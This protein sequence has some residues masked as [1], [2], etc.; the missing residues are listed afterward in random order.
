MIIADA[1]CVVNG[2]KVNE[3]IDAINSLLNMDIII[4]N[5]SQP[6]IQFS[7]SAV[8]IVI[9]PAGGGSTNEQLDIV[10]SNNAASSRWFLTTTE[11]GDAD[12]S[13]DSGGGDSIPNIGSNGGQNNSSGA[14][15]DRDN[16]SG[17]GGGSMQNRD[18]LNKTNA[19]GA[20]KD[21]G[22]GMPQRPKAPQVDE[23]G[24]AIGGGGRGALKD[25]GQTA[26][27]ARK[28]FM[29]NKKRAASDVDF[30]KTDD[31]GNVLKPDGTKLT[32]GGARL[33]DGTRP[34]NQKQPTSFDPPLPGAPPLNQDRTGERDA[35]K[36]ADG[37]KQ[38]D[39]KGDA[40]DFEENRRKQ[41]AFRKKKQQYSTEKFLQDLATKKRQAEAD[42]LGRHNKMGGKYSKYS[43]G[44]G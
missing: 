18:K 26:E 25:N 8:Q 14:L 44:R 34:V 28:N 41:E 24:N 29:A 17:G 5:V 42:R 21:D 19:V 30:S 20:L 15:K 22:A 13:A 36:N 9:P 33:D 11:Q 40:R 16:L 31:F 39:F 12:A 32:P 35:A 38:T 3:A 6:Q 2:P 43:R 23:F 27:Q 4:G 10:D 7:S 1:K 37:R